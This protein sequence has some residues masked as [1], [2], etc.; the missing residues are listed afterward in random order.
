MDCVRV[1]DHQDLSRVVLFLKRSDYKMLSEV[2]HVNALDR[3]NAREPDRRLDQQIN[4][5][6]A[7]LLIAGWRLDF[8]QRLDKR[9]DLSLPVLHSGKKLTRKLPTHLPAHL[10]ASL[11][12][13]SASRRPRL[14]SKPMPG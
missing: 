4:N 10:T 14:T 7:A 1:S 11:R 3:I 12:T 5:S 6:A 8:N 9:L 2:R 13:V